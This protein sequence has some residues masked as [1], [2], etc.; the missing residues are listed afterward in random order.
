MLEAVL[1]EKPLIFSYDTDEH[2]QDSDVYKQISEV[3][4]NSQH[5]S[6]ENMANLEQVLDKALRQGIDK[7]AWR[8]TRDEIF[9]NADGTSV[10][11]IAKFIRDIAADTR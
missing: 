7:K 4:E 3:V 9:Y 11:T 8:K 6:L 5:L 1:T 10:R 2:R